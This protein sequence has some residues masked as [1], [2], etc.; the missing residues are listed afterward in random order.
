MEKWELWVTAA[1]VPLSFLV[2]YVMVFAIA[3]FAFAKIVGYDLNHE[4]ASRHNKAVGTAYSGYLIAVTIV[5]IG[6]LAG[7]TKGFVADVASVSAYSALGVVLLLVSRA[8]NDRLILK[9]FSNHDELIRDQNVGTGAVL[10][11]SYVASGLIVAGAVHGEGGGVVTATAFFLLGQLSLIIFTW[12]YNRIT[13]YD[14]H[15]QIEKDNVAVGV[16]FGGTLVALGIILMNGVAGGFTSWSHNLGRFALFSLGAFVVLP[17]F[18][19]FMDK[20][21]LSHYDLNREL[22]SDANV[23]AG[24]LEAA[25]VICFAAVISFAV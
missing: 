12:L 14:V 23:A 24:L 4:V 17:L 16:A 20:V 13:P 9:E 7:P 19:L 25:M 10:F 18:R 1:G 5:F 22:H 15:E 21:L 11:G 3:K 6:A 8:V 2:L